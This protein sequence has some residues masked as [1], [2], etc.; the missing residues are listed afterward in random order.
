MPFGL[1]VKGLVA[2]LVVIGAFILMGIP[3]AE[4]RTLD[5]ANVAFSSGALML[6]LGFYFGHI[7]GA[8]TALANNAT[9]L[10]AQAITAVGQRRAGDPT[11]PSVPGMVPV[12]VVVTNPPAAPPA[13]P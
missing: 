10:A 9:A 12:A 6:V 4:N 2:V 13:A 3:V 1:D 5:T 11:P 7:N 8:A